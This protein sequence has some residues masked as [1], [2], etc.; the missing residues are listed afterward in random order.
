MDHRVVEHLDGDITMANIQPGK[1]EKYYKLFPPPSEH[2]V[3]E[4]RFIQTYVGEVLAARCPG[5]DYVYT[6]AAGDEHQ[7]FPAGT[8]WSDIPDDWFCP[9]CGVREKIDF[10]QIDPETLEASA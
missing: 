4:D 1:E 10:V 6:V 2:E 7:G 8:A 5:C 3:H 9:D